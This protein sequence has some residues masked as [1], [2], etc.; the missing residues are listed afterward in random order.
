MAWWEFLFAK[1]AQRKHVSA[2]PELS[3]IPASDDLRHVRETPV[4][5]FEYQAIHNQRIATGRIIH[6]WY[7]IAFAASPLIFGLILGLAKDQNGRFADGWLMLAAAG[8]GAAPL[9]VALTFVLCFLDKAI[10]TYYPRLLAL[11]IMLGFQ[12]WR[13]ALR[14]QGGAAYVDKCESEASQAVRAT[15]LWDR[16]R[17]VAVTGLSPWNRGHK[18]PAFAALLFV[19]LYL[20]L[21]GYLHL[22]GNGEWQRLRK[23]WGS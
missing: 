1:A 12:F 14:G 19:V 13:H 15:E 6:V 10:V 18:F 9:V 16:V 23:L 5:H 7:Q 3:A 17:C 8:A 4:F 2:V 22:S 11:E 20:L 21:I